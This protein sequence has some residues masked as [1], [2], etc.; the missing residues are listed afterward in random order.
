[1]MKDLFTNFSILISLM[2]LSSQLFHWK[3]VEKLSSLHKK[4]IAGVMAGVLGNVL[5]QNTIQIQEG[6]FVDMRI[7]PIAIIALHG[8][9]VSGFIG[10]FLIS[11]G[12]LALFD[13][14]S[15]AVIAVIH[16]FLLML[17][18]TRLAKLRAHDWL[19]FFYLMLTWAVTGF[20]SL[21][22]ATQNVPKVLSF[23][24]PYVAAVAGS[25]FM[26]YYLVRFLYQSHMAIERFREHATRDFLTGLNNVRMFDDMFNS[27]INWAE[28]RGEKLSLLLL[29]IDY[30]KK[31][32]D[33]FGH[34]TGDEVLHQLGHLLPGVARPFDT[35][36]R[37]GGEE[38]TVLLPDCPHVQAIEVGERIRKAVENH[39]FKIELTGEQ[40]HVTVSVGVS[41][42]KDTVF[43]PEMVYKEADEALYLAKKSG[44][45]RVCSL[46]YHGLSPNTI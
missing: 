39:I 31:I 14:N 25:A 22:L 20:I 42:Y 37:N 44:R 45:N 41:T 40:I 23:F 18:G 12:R 8:G 43:Q 29:D 11:L 46:R 13:M 30:F 34:I 19:K 32:N 28:R 9:I 35:I 4:I 24:G 10:C 7:I 27:S 26:S 5:M 36:S 16:I 15:A 6:V 2:F 3:P 21:S 38:F 17:I 1:M 33:N